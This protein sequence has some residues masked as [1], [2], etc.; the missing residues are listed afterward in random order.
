[1]G[2]LLKTVGYSIMCVPLF[3]KNQMPH[4]THETGSKLNGHGNM[5]QSSFEE[6]GQCVLVSGKKRVTNVIHS[7]LQW[8]THCYSQLEMKQ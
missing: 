3:G 2:Y 1:M 4:E 8:E 6:T 7:V 5:L